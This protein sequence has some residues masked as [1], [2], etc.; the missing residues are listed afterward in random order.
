M[1]N[2]GS[3]VTPGEYNVIIVSA[4]DTSVAIVCSPE[5]YNKANR[6]KSVPLQIRHHS[7]K[8]RRYS[9]RS[10]TK[11]MKLKNW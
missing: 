1:S 2:E 8:W 10:L 5:R 4:T 7:K 6:P 3:L 11:V 9:K